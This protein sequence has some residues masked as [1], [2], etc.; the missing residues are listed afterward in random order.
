MKTIFFGL[1]IKDVENFEIYINKIARNLNVSNMI[2]FLQK[3]NL[4]FLEITQNE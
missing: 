4:K 3:I 1:P 2:T